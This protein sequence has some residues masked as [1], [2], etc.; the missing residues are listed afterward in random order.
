MESSELRFVMSCWL[1]TSYEYFYSSFQR[2]CNVSNAKTAFIL[3]QFP[4][5]ICGGKFELLQCLCLHESCCHVSSQ[6]ADLLIKLYLCLYC[7]DH[8]ALDRKG[9]KL[10]CIF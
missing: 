9:L 8:W 1:L 2:C 5:S 7:L 6:H 10:K 4:C 3:R